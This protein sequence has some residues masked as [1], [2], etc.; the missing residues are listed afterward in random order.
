MN[1]GYN[2]QDV[3]ALST[4][5]RPNNADRGR[6]AVP[7][8]QITPS[9]SLYQIEEF[10]SRVGVDMY[11]DDACWPWKGAFDSHG[12]GSYRWSTRPLRQ[13]MAHR[14]AF[15]LVRG[16]VPDGLELDHLCRNTKCCNPRHL[17]PVTHA[18]NIRRRSVAQTSCKRGHEF[19]TENTRRRQGKGREC[20]TCVRAALRDAWK[21]GARKRGRNG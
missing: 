6:I 19:T 5:S 21:R 1:T 16:G 15:I 10:W 11:D 18:E 14:I 7:I 20:R 2:G 17:E 13:T 4:S 9:L 3:T 8:S 12:Y